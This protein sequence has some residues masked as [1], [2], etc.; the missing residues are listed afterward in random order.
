LKTLL[1][2]GIGAGCWETSRPSWSRYK[3]KQDNE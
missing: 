1:D 3:P 2:K